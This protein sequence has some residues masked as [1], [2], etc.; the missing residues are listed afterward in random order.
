M[1]CRFGTTSDVDGWRE[2]SDFPGR[3]H[4]LEHTRNDLCRAGAG[5]L[6]LRLDFEQ[7]GVGQGG[8]QLVV[9]LMKQRSQVRG[10]PLWLLL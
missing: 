7:F 6:V 1:L 9:Q 4:R 3:A 8:A 10:L 2:L 5:R